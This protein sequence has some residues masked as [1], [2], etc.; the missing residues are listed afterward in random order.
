MQTMAVVLPVHSQAMRRPRL[1]QRVAT[2]SAGV[3]RDGSRFLIV[4]LNTLNRYVHSPNVSVSP[5]HL[6]MLWATLA[7]FVV[8]C[9]EA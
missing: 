3:D 4:S 5:E 6:K 2:P 8:L 9:L 7:D 1:P